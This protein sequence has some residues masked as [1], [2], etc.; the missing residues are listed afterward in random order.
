MSS[1]KPLLCHSLL[2]K[3]QKKQNT[4]SLILRERVRSISPGG[5]PR[6]RLI[7]IAMLPNNTAWPQVIMK[8]LICIQRTG[9]HL[10]C[11]SHKQLGWRGEWR[12]RRCLTAQ[13]KSSF[14]P[15]RRVLK[16]LYH[17]P[18]C[19]EVLVLPVILPGGKWVCW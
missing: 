2:L 16:R 8:L 4:F 11:Y 10:I 13:P 14:S 1:S 19:I 9:F 12:S 3:L 6:T 15:E 18:H 7:F 5:F 17:L